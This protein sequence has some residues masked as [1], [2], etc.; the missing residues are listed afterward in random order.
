VGSLGGEVSGQCDRRQLTCLRILVITPPR[1]CSKQK[2]MMSKGRSDGREQVWFYTEI[3][4]VSV[5]HEAGSAEPKAREDL[6]L[7]TRTHCPN[8]QQFFHSVDTT[9]QRPTRRHPVSR[10]RLTP[11]LARG[12]AHA[13]PP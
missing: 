1:M 4:F 9:K 10:P 3:G 6:Q 8:Q 2:T 5:R 7:D 13:T 12:L 11:V